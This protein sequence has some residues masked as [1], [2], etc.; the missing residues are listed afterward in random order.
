MEEI[1]RLPSRYSYKGTRSVRLV[2]KGHVVL[3]MKW[4]DTVQN[5]HEQR[6]PEFKSRL[7]GCGSF[8]DA[9]SVRTDAPAS[10]LETHSI[11]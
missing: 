11:A 10:D 4:V 5:I 3:P 9:T 6:K 7:V 2:S 1:S 8:K